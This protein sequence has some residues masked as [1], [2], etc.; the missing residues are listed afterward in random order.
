MKC[1][2]PM[3]VYMDIVSVGTDMLNQV[4]HGKFLLYENGGD[5]DEYNFLNLFDKVQQ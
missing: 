1:F 5:H 2:I 3:Y 4:D